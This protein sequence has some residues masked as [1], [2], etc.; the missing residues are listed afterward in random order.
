MH[1]VLKSLVNK[2]EMHYQGR[3]AGGIFNSTWHKETRIIVER[4]GRRNNLQVAKRSKEERPI[5]PPDSGIY[6][7]K[8]H[9]RE[10]AESSG[11][12]DFRAK[13]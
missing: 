12:P 8:Q 10:E 11:K 4:E 6:E 1:W 5:S 13:G 2:Q 9:L 3:I 7:K